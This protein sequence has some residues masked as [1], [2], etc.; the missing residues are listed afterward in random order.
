MNGT[1]SPRTGASAARK[2]EK[3]IT[4]TIANTYRTKGEKSRE[5]IASIIR[6]PVVIHSFGPSRRLKNPWPLLPVTPLLKHLL[7]PQ[8]V[9]KS[10]QAIEDRY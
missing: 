8:Q 3:T 2:R 10:F 6:P 9:R 5:K 4:V 1:P 7:F